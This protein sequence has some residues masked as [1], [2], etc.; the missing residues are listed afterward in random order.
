MKKII[1]DFETP[2]SKCWDL[3]GNSIV[4]MNKMN[5]DNIHYMSLED[6]IR[7]ISMK[8]MMHR[9][10]REKLPPLTFILMLLTERIKKYEM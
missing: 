10:L 7:G 4:I 9:G 8:E 6:S 1:L 3:A 5:T 2:C